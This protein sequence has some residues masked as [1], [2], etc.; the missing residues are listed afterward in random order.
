MIRFRFDIK[1]SFFLAVSVVTYILA[2]S[3]LSAGELQRV[4]LES[5]DGTPIMGYMMR[6]NGS[7]PFPAVVALHGCG[8]LFSGKSDKL[9]SRHKDWGNRLVKWGYVVLFPSSF[10]SRGLGPLCKIRRRPVKQKDRM[11]DAESALIWLTTQPYIQKDHIS[12]LGWSNG[13]GTALR[14]AFSRHG[15]GFRH[16]LAFYPGCSSMAR[17]KSLKLS[18]ALTILMGRADDWTPYEP[19][20]YLIETWGGKIILYK[21]A[22]HSFDTPNSPVRKRYGVAY[23]KSGNGIVHIGTNQKA[24]KQ[25]IRDVRNILTAK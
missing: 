21:N 18:T 24:R 7:G 1:G 2:S 25:A 17:R 4:Q 12:L 16:I 19:C 11:K 15:R 5:T 3:A 9:S 20:E 13:G 22:Y 10:R 14:L 23:S 8:G 6:P